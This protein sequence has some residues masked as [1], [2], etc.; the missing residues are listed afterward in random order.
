MLSIAVDGANRKWIGT[1]K[2]GVYLLSA[3]GLEAIHHFTTE[4][5]PLPSNEV[6]S[7]VTDEL[8]GMVYIGTNEGLIAYQSDATETQ[9]SFNES[10]VRAYPN[11]VRPDYQGYIR[12]DETS[13]AAG[14]SES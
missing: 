9:T 3:N 6:Q 14:L 12:I 11:P 8:T 5:S 2:N 4:N 10:R 7:I 1:E 13:I